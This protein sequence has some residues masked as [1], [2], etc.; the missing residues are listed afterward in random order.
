MK[1]SLRLALAAMQ[2]RCLALNGLTASRDALIH[3]GQ[4]LDKVFEA[5]L[6]PQPEDARKKLIALMERARNKDEEAVTELNALRSQTIDLYVRAMSNFI[7]FFEPVNLDP[8]EQVKWTNTFRNPV[9]VRYVGQDGGPRQVKAVKAQKHT[10]IDMREIETDEVGYQIRDINLGTDIGAAA[11]A[12]VDLGWDMSNKVDKEAFTLLTTGQSQSAMGIYG[13]FKLTGAKLDRTWIPNDRIIA[14]NLPD[15]NHLVLEDNGAGAGQ[16]NRFRFAVCRAIVK[17]CERWGNVWGTPIRPTGIIMVPSIDC[18]DL[19][20]EIEPTSL[21]FPNQ[22]A[23]NVLQNYSQF[24]YLGIKWTL[25]PDVTLTQG[26]CYPVLNRPIGQVYYK[27]S[28]D[29][30]I[31]ETNRRKNWETRV[32]KKVINF[33]IPEPWRVNALRVVYN[34]S[35]E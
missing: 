4:S 27:P 6:K 26:L 1:P 11:Q 19:A 20:E 31:V 34:E 29:E 9:G 24:T 2:G 35:A 14:A 32:Q 12:T 15:T 10:F 16:S 22:V 30:E 18:T 7:A 3:N 33:T 28:M 23:E 8:D 13:P 25:V 21:I 5:A 17:Y